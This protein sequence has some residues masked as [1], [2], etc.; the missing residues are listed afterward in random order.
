MPAELVKGVE[1]GILFPLDDSSMF[2]NGDRPLVLEPEPG[3]LFLWNDWPRK[4][5][6]VESEVVNPSKIDVCRN[7][8]RSEGLQQ[9]C[10]SRSQ[11]DLAPNHIKRTVL[12]GPKP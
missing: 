11:H 7:R 3:P 2:V 9:L 1:F 5:A 12:C 4:P 8:A 10:G 6:H